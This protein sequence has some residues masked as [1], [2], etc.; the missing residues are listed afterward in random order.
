METAHGIQALASRLW[1]ALMVLPR[2]FSTNGATRPPL[3]RAKSD[4]PPKT[5]I[6][7]QRDPLRTE[8]DHG[9]AARIEPRAV[10][11]PFRHRRDSNEGKDNLSRRKVPR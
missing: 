8:N 4:P 2:K 6:V 3:T 9:G 10:P 5:L 1:L 7:S 11:L